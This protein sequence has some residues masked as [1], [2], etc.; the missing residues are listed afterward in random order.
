MIPLTLDA[1]YDQLGE[2]ELPR[3]HRQTDP[4]TVNRQSDAARSWAAT[5]RKI[6]GITL[7]KMLEPDEMLGKLACTLGR[8]KEDAEGASSGVHQPPRSI[9]AP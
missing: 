5:R 2:Q 1:Y 6:Y 9:P 7:A 3:T 8:V 4:A